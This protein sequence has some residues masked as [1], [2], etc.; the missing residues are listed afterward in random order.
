MRATKSEIDDSTP[1][2]VSGKALMQQGL[3]VEMKDRREAV[4]FVDKKVG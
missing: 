1:I 4:I 2:T 3:H